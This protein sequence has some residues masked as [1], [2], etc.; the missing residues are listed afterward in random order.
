M[1]QV[2]TSQQVVCFRTALEALEAQRLG[3]FAMRSEHS[4]GRVTAEAAC[5]IRTDFQRDRDRILHSKAFRRLKHKT[6]VFISP[7][8]DHFRTRLTHSLEVSQIARTV[9]R[10]LQLNEDL[11]EAVALGH[12]IGHPPFGHAGEEIL[13]RLSPTGFCHSEHS[14]RIATVLEPLNLT[15]EVL[16]GIAQQVSDVL[17][18]AL[19]ARVVEL[20]DRMAYLRHDMEDAIRAGM[21]QEAEVP[22]DIVAVLGPTRSE[23]LDRMVM[24]LIVTS[25]AR[26][27]AGQPEI[28]HSDEIREA[29]WALRQWMFDRVYLSAPQR[30]KDKKVERV[31]TA[32]FEHFTQ[33]P[34]AIGEDFEPSAPVERR[35]VDYIA[36]MTD[37]FALDT[38]L[39]TQLPRAYTGGSR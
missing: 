34:D 37:R 29:I 15:H 27:D 17:P 1:A 10:V 20:C 35:V 28:Q 21:I 23:R 33:H 30:E 18:D 25:K 11:T 3:P 26:L 16:S 39:N 13:H 19:E 4:K 6:Q 36:G 8:G 7:I 24:D 9:A 12:D 31:L 14:V 22:R 5:P 32:L 2:N 38:Y